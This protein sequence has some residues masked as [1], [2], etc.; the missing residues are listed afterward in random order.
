MHDNDGSVSYEND[1]KHYYFYVREVLVQRLWIVTIAKTEQQKNLG[2][3]T[4][5]KQNFTAKPQML[6]TLVHR[7]PHMC[8]AYNVSY[9]KR[10]CLCI[11]N[12]NYFL[13][14][15]KDKQIHC[16]CV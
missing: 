7:E 6:T 4:R 3:F 10:S 2:S 13:R 12:F 1:P 15:G 14:G 9:N 16:L 8:I 5:N 11:S